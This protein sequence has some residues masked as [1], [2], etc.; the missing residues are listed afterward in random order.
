MSV[1][2]RILLIVAT[3]TA[4]PPAQ[5][6][7]VLSAGSAEERADTAPV[8]DRCNAPEPPDGR[9]TAEQL[10]E[11]MQWIAKRFG[12]PGSAE[13]PAIV[14]ERPADLT[15]MR[16][17][18]FVTHPTTQNAPNAEHRSG[19][20]EVLALYNDARRIIH[21]SEDWSGASDSDMSVL[22][23]E[24]VHHLQN[25]A[26]LKYYCASEREKIAYQAQSA[27]LRQF[28]K[29][30]DSEFGLDPLTLLVRSSCL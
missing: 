13:R 23:H 10:D 14:F 4:V 21:L 26:G 16:N 30:L 6:T 27:W 19:R 25:L 1:Y 12:L 2:A 18:G 24:M 5:A 20:G 8:A 17:G 11:I 7:C 3:M 29:S 22:V 9:V 28:D 15:R